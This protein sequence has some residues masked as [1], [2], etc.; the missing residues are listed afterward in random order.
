MADKPKSIL[1]RV[2]NDGYRE[3]VGQTSQVKWDEAYERGRQD[4]LKEPGS[5]RK[6]VF[7]AGFA[8]ASFLFLL[9][10]MIQP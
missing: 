8:F 3:G 10:G 1:A 2:H 6:I 5:S 7:F 4:A 9:A